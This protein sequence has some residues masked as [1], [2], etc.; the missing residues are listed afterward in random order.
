MGNVKW[1]KQANTY[2]HIASPLSAAQSGK[3]ET[4]VEGTF[5]F[6]F[7]VRKKPLQSKAKGYRIRPVGTW[8]GWVCSE[9]DEAGF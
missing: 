9:V 4:I 5:I 6:F 7:S 1:G 8:S 3:Q 2:P